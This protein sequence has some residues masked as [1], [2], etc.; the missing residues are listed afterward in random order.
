MRAAGRTIDTGVPPVSPPVS[1]PPH[2]STASER[3]THLGSQPLVPRLQRLLPAQLLAELPDQLRLP[4]AVRLL[5]RPRVLRLLPARLLLDLLLLLLLLLPPHLPPLQLLQLQPTLLLRRPVFGRL[6]GWRP[7][8][9]GRLVARALR[10]PTRLPPHHSARRGRGR[11]AVQGPAA[12]AAVPA[13]GGARLLQLRP[14][15]FQR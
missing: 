11:P 1:L 13:A 4:A 10:D 15:R 2:A 6:C 9:A 7:L 3:H 12:A 8:P 5:Q 14:D